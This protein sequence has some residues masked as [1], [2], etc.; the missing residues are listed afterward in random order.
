MAIAMIDMKFNPNYETSTSVDFTKST[1]DAAQGDWLREDLQTQQKYGPFY[2][3]NIG[4]WEPS[5][6]A[7]EGRWAGIEKPTTKNEA[8]EMYALGHYDQ[9]KPWK[10]YTFH[11]FP[12]RNVW[13]FKSKVKG[14]SS[15][16]IKLPNPICEF[17]IVN[18][19]EQLD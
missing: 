2:R 18:K 3:V 17:I 15:I 11:I 14:G 12:N 7:P 1:L 19:V 6:E 16:Q 10:L 8:N 9:N 13:L 4:D 5:R